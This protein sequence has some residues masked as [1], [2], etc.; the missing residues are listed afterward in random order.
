MR[1]VEIRLG[2]YELQMDAAGSWNGIGEFPT[3]K[4][5]QIKALEIIRERDK[6]SF[7]PRVVWNEIQSA[8]GGDLVR[9]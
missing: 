7:K 8:E 3:Q 9:S 2:V 1:I 4:Q 6:P 5:A